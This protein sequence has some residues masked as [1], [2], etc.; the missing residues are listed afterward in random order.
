MVP[1]EGADGNIWTLRK[2]VI[3]QW[4][5]LHKEGLHNS[6]NSTNIKP[7]TVLLTKYVE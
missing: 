1:A 3:G 6:Y 5:K 4:K 2:D 7:R